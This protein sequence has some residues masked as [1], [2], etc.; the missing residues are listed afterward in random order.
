MLKVISFCSVHLLPWNISLF[1][2]RISCRVSSKLI[3]HPY[4][5]AIAETTLLVVPE[6]TLLESIFDC[7]ARC[8]LPQEINLV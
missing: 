6:L 4:F 3:W 8:W 2:L 5:S 7:F 1:A